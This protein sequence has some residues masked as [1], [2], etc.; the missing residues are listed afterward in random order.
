V[1]NSQKFGGCKVRDP[2][3]CQVTYLYYIP[4]VNTVNE[5]CGQFAYRREGERVICRRPGAWLKP[6]AYMA[7]GYMNLDRLLYFVT[8]AMT[9]ENGSMATCLESLVACWGEL[10]ANTWIFGVGNPAFARSSGTV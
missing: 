6:S 7:I 2:S 1:V 8:F 10:A 4:L 3:G 9:A 5:T